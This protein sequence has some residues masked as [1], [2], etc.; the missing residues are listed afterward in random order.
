MEKHREAMEVLCRARELAER[1][2]GHESAPEYHSCLNLL[3]H[4]LSKTGELDLDESP[5]MA[6]DKFDRA[7]E[8]K[9]T[10]PSCHSART[11]AS[12]LR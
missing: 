6:V 11:V 5:E 2:E 3:F 1:M 8:N 12:H 10:A 9:V 4:A 7:L